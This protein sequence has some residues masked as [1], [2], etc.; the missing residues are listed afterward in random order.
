MNERAVFEAWL[1][2]YQPRDPS[3]CDSLEH[4]LWAAWQAALSRAPVGVQ[5]VIEAGG[6][7]HI[8]EFDGARFFVN[9]GRTRHFI[10]G[11]TRAWALS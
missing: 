4:D 9:T 1:R 8:A 3:P 2:S 10:N 11:V 6:C 5:I 7:L